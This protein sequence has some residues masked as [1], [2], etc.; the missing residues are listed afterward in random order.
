MEEL[1]KRLM[2]LQESFL[3]LSLRMR[4]GMIAGLVVTL[5]LVGWAYSLS[6]RVEYAVLFSNLDEGDAAQVIKKLAE[7]RIVYKVEAG[8]TIM[9]PADHVYE[10]RLSMASEGLPHG[11]GVGFE[12]FDQQRF[13]ESEFAEQVKYHRALEGELVR[14]IQS[15][16]GVKSAR[17]HL[18]LPNRSLFTTSENTASAS[19]AITLQPGVHLTAEQ[20]RGIVHLVASSVRGLTAQGVTVV[21]GEGRALASGDDIEEEQASRSLEFRREVEKGKE[22]AVQQMLD[23]TLGPGVAIVRV[24]ADV[25]FTREEATEEAFDNDSVAERSHTLS[26]EYDP[27]S[28]GVPIAQ[29]VPGTPANLPG[30]TP[31]LNPGA[32]PGGATNPTVAATP[33]GAGTATTQLATPTPPVPAAPTP[34]AASASTAVGLLHHTETRNYEISHVTRHKLEPV[35]RLTRFDI[36]VVVDYLNRG[37]AKK[38]KFEARTDAE[39]QEI[40]DIVTSAAGAQTSRGDRVTVKSVRFPHQAIPAEP[41]DVLAPVR[42]FLPMGI[43]LMIALGGIFGFLALYRMIRKGFETMQPQAEQLPPGEE[44][45]DADQIGEGQSVA[46]TLQL[47]ESAAAA[48]LR[49]RKAGEPDP[50]VL[51]ASEIAN[52]DPALAANVIRA[53]LSEGGA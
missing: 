19:V 13:G 37:D 49:E 46:E 9:V 1:R 39:I 32:T 53:W 6:T 34:T 33:P 8:H 52:S 50:L 11:G 22:R 7:K 44:V 27:K 20:V 21:D 30:G 42:P 23:A 41:K 3:K 18:V 5:A 48:A 51:A 15:L 4:M 35:G 45:S 16:E 25:S 31:N 17:V 26:D 40:A 24:A 12:I 43:P 14:T 47:G 36:A 29:G 10:T 38:P 2:Q 28:T